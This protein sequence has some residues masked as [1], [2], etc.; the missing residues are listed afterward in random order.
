VPYRVVLEPL[1]QDW[2][3]RQPEDVRKRVFLIL[4]TFAEFADQAGKQLQNPR[5][6][7]DELGWARRI[8]LDSVQPGLRC[9]YFVSARDNEMIVVNFGT[10]SDDI[11]EDGN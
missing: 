1:A 11:Y 2:I 4:N 10:H 5:W 9:I 3:D 8:V 6:Y 7:D